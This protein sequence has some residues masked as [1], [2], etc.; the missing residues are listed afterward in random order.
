MQFIYNKS[1]KLTRKELNQQF[2]Y[3]TYGK[4]KKLSKSETDHKNQRHGP[5]RQLRR[6]LLSLLL[7]LLLFMVPFKDQCSLAP[8]QVW[9]K[10]RRRG[11]KRGG[12][13]YAKILKLDFAKLVRVGNNNNN[14]F[15]SCCRGRCC[16]APSTF[17]SMIA[18]KKNNAPNLVVPQRLCS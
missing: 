4:K 16:P 13:R 15:S 1:Q 12:D 6:L 2:L 8:H 9:R 7:F 11:V 5:K 18:K 14:N 3:A 17:F 10:K